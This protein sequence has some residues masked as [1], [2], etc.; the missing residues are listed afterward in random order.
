MLTFAQGT[1]SGDYFVSFISLYDEEGTD[2][3]L[4][5]TVYHSCHMK[6]SMLWRLLNTVLINF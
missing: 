4:L 5:I 1:Y 6:E 3:S 2:L